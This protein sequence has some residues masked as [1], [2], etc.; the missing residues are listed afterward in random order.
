MSELSFTYRSSAGGGGDALVGA[1]TVTVVSGS[2]FTLI[3][4]TG[5]TDTQHENIDSLVHSISEDTYTELVRNSASQVITVNQ[6]QFIGGPLVRK[7]EINRNTNGQVTGTVERQYDG[8]GTLIQSLTTALVRDS[9]G[10]V[11]TITTIEV[12]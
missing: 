11:T 5:I 8:G 3:S 7:T 1:G 10:S 2:N 9:N 6:Y 12:P 4:G